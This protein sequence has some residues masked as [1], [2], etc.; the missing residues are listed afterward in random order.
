VIA[1]SGTSGTAKSV[2]LSHG[3]VAHAATV[4]M[5]RLD[6]GPRDVWL[7]CLPM[8][9]VGG[10]GIILRSAVSGC[11]LVLCDHFEAAAI[12][13]LLDE[14]ITIISLVPT[15]LHRLV[16]C[17]AGRPW[18][19]TL[20]CLLIG[21]GPLSHD[22][23]ARSTALGLAP[24]ETYGLTEAA[25]QVC[26]LAPHESADHPGCAGRTL[27]GMEVVIRDAEGKELPDDIP[28]RI[29]IRGDGLF[30]GYEHQGRLVEPHPAGTWFATGDVGCLHHGGYLSILG[31]HDDM[32]IS[33]GEN[34]APAEIEAVLERHPA[35]A[36]AGVYGLADAEWGQ[37]VA[38]ALVPHN[39]PVP[40]ADLDAFLR[41]HLPGFKRPRRITW[42]RGLP[43]TAT[44]K[45]QRSRLATWGGG[46]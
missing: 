19:A 31:R 22:L 32:I 42:V 1:T 24:C 46:E 15:M 37:M 5:R 23:I 18:P 25:S 29:W 4:A 21:G 14:G 28:G 2:R 12:D 16:E 6:L 45:L 8:D 36:Q 39:Q 41:A 20:R 34:I 33:G 43:T 10:M 17:R 35:V 26:T 9:H 30:D 11:R 7:A 44:G 13:H 27:D 3:A 38:A 40:D